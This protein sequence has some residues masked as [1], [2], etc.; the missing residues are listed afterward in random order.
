MLPA[1][2]GLMVLARPLVSTLFGGG[3]FDAYAV[4]QTAGALV[5]YSIGLSSYGA[6]KI[7]QSCFFALKDTRTPAKVTFLAFITN[8]VLNAILMFPLK[9]GG[10]AL[11]TS[12][13]GICSFL[14]LLFL[15]KDKIGDF[16]SRKIASSFLRMLSASLGMGAVCYF[17]SRMI[18]FNKSIQL[19]LGISAGVFSYI[20]FCLVFKVKEMQEFK[21]WFT[22]R[23][24][25]VDVASAGPYYPDI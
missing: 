4:S 21:H 16:H 20:L 19:S 1:S 11:A 10:I 25:E 23:E 18:S 17:V 3:R 13:S 2:V 8:I 5:F 9:I 12:I 6:T 14:L 22:R 7:L 24:L 15:L